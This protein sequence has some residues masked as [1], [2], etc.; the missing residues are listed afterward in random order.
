MANN[1]GSFRPVIIY[2]NA[3]TDKLRILTDNKGKAGIYMWTH[4]ESGKIYIGSA[5]DL[6][7]RISQYFL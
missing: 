2:N 4:I 5:F 3:E 6:Y 1:N 7:K